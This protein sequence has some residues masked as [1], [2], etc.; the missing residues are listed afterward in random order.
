MSAFSPNFKAYQ[1]GFAG[2]NDKYH[3]DFEKKKT[4]PRK[5]L[6]ICKQKS[7]TNQTQQITLNQ[8]LK[9]LPN[10]T[11]GFR[12][13]NS[14]KSLPIKTG[15]QAINVIEILTQT[16]WATNPKSN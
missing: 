5:C 9:S 16:N 6:N 2:S 8:I 12:M 7:V 11:L 1:L 15:F 4:L 10:D 14:L 3:R 13:L